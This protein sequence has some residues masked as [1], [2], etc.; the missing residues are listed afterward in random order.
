MKKA[1]AYKNYAKTAEA[2][3]GG[4][5]QNIRRDRICAVSWRRVG[6][7]S[8]AVNGLVRPLT[9]PAM[10]MQQLQDGSFIN[11]RKTLFPN[12]SDECYLL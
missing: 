7:A 9:Q 11:N 6:I 4:I 3:S 10:C 12:L 8:I 2:G 5:M 1:A